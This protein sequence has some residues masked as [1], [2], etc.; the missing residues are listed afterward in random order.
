MYAFYFFT[1]LFTLVLSL[2]NYYSNTECRKKAAFTGVLEDAQIKII[3]IKAYHKLKNRCSFS[4]SPTL[5]Q[6]AKSP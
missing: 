1:L 6:Y 3:L 2:T 4:V 5:A